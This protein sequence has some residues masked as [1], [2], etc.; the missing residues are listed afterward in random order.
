M[1]ALTGT[2]KALVDTNV[3][4]YAHNS[5]DPTKQTT[6]RQLIDRL[7]QSRQIVLSV[8]NLNEFYWSITR[9]HRPGH[10]THDEASLIVTDSVLPLRSFH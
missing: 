1:T 8:Q 10:L 4:V 3:L 6:A 7:L 2:S 5:A 9:P